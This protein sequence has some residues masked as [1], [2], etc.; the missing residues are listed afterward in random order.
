MTI[1]F[2]GFLEIKK[3]NLHLTDLKTK[4]ELDVTNLSENEIIR[5]LENDEVLLDDFTTMIK[6]SDEC[7]INQQSCEYSLNK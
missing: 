4:K 1:N 3:E 5:K 7:D 2:N 6:N